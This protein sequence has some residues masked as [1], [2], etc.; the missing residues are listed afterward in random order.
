MTTLS[1]P[2]TTSDGFHH[3]VYS[4][5]GTTHTLFFD[6]SAVSININSGNIFSLFPNISNL[7]CGTAG[8]LSYGYTGFLDDVKIFNRALTT[9]DV[10]AI[11]N[12]G[13]FS[14]SKIGIIDLLSVS[15]RNALINPSSNPG[16][17]TGGAFA[18]ALK[19]LYSNYLGPVVQIQRSS[20]N[21]VSDIYAD[22]SGNLG[23]GYLGTGTPFSTWLNSSIAYVVKLYDQTN[24][25][26]H[27]IGVKTTGYNLPFISNARINP[28][29]NTSN[30]SYPLGY[31]ICF[32]N[33]SI[34]NA[35][36][37]PTG[38]YLSI[39]NGAYPW[40]GSNYSTVTKTYV[41]NN[42]KTGNGNSN[43]EAI[44]Y[45][46][47][48]ASN[49]SNQILTYHNIQAG[50]GIVTFASGSGNIAGKDYSP[51]TGGYYYLNAPV[52]FTYNYNNNLMK[53]FPNGSNTATSGNTRNNNKVLTSNS[54]N[55]IGYGS[56]NSQNSST[57]CFYYF[58]ALP[59]DLADA[60]ADK[61]ILESTV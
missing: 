34:S 50:Y 47:T 56:I 35:N 57:G 61:A 25:G 45:S 17:G 2:I 43:N 15:T 32:N 23:T 26:N 8:D 11:Y 54:G 41:V 19:L 1:T 49:S 44:F 21:A 29:G 36:F 28:V 16:G 55:Y 22:V 46:G 7:F 18:Y 14:V 52:T 37:T 40:N 6:N 39:P 3:L 30:A 9:T 5:S 59:I 10:S 38:N 42:I 12:T 4:I 33:G 20:D 53:I 51:D 58:Y 27:A 31:Y 48:T 60:L 24:N 13:N